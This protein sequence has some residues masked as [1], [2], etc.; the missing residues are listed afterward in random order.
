M[1]KKQYESPEMLVI[2]IADEDVIT[3]SNEI[4]SGFVGGD[5]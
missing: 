3:A 4:D 2:Q 5:D 1:D